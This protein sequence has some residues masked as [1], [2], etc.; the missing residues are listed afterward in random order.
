MSLNRCEDAFLAY[1]R[2]HPDEQRFWT[3]RVLETDRRGGSSDMRASAL[4][5]ELRAYAA[6]RG[7]VMA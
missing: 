6:E 7:E 4:E 2:A 1:L 5:L 3:A